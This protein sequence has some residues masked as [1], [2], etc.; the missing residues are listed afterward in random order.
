MAARPVQLLAE[1]L[2]GGGDDRPSAA[3][4]AAAAAAIKQRFAGREAEVDQL[5]EEFGRGPRL[6]GPC[7]VYGT[8][9]TGKTTVVRALLQALRVRHAYVNC[10]ESSRPRPLLCSLLHQLKGG[11]RQRDE[12]Y[13]CAVK[14]DGIAEFQLALPG[15]VGQRGPC[16]LVLEHADRLAGTDLLS[17][18]LRVREDTGAQVAVLLIGR[19]GW[20]SGRYLR[21]TAGALPPQEVHFAAYAPDQLEKI[22]AR[23]WVALH[24][25]G[26]AHPLRQFLHAFVPS[27]CRASNNLLDLQAA[28]ARLFPLYMQPLREGRQL[29]APSLYGRIKAEVQQCMQGLQLGSGMQQPQQQQHAAAQ[30]GEGEAGAVRTAA[31]RRA[32]STGLAFE[33][34]YVSKFLLLAA[35]IA[36]RNKPT[37][38]RAV[39]DPGFRKRGRRDA[40]AM[41]RQAEAAVEA[42]LRGPH[43]FPLERLL[44]IFWAI[45]AHHDAE[46]EEEGREGEGDERR[47]A[48][49]V[50]QQAEVLHQVSSLVSLRLLDQ[51]S[52]DILEGQLYRC[53]LGEDMAGALAAN[54][55]LRLGDYLRLS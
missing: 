48:Q 9:A 1:S 2:A 4:V 11:K 21:D 47:E 25:E 10:V 37:T 13:E 32:C 12:L 35:H 51:C 18:L 40:Q 46:D 5:A 14:C 42:K 6:A 28:V 15:I 53:N 19:A 34:P 41:D 3:S 33:L 8:S 26:D 55:R 43:S 30:G 27:F 39:F 52:G 49:R 31:Q 22:M 17:A 38:D 44:H 24:G 20:G 23:R 45:F 7:L 36:S 54:V 16:W 50:M 29:Q